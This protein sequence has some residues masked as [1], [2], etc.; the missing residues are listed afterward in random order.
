MHGNTFVCYLTCL[1]NDVSLSFN[2]YNF[3]RLHLSQ[4]DLSQFFVRLFAKWVNRLAFCDSVWN[5]WSVTSALLGDRMSHLGTRHTRVNSSDIDVSSV[6]GFW[7]MLGAGHGMFIPV[8]LVGTPAVVMV[9][10]SNWS[11][12]LLTV[13]TSSHSSPPPILLHT[14]PPLLSSLH[15]SLSPPLFSSTVS[16]HR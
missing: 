10:L 8:T 3:I 11:S 12:V 15:S 2:E 9:T 4:F 5:V 13:R 14:P 1:F 7:S 16:V 6:W